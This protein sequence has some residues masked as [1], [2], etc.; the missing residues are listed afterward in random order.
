MVNEPYAHGTIS[1]YKAKK[2]RCDECRA[3]Q[4]EY[5][6]AWRKA[7]G[8]KVGPFNLVC[9]TCASTFVARTSVVKYCSKACLPKPE[10][11]PRRSTCR[12]CR[13]LYPVAEDA[14]R[15]RTGLCARCQ[16]LVAKNQE[17]CGLCGVRWWS[18][19]GQ[20]F[21]S[22]EC[23]NLNDARQAIIEEDYL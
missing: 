7:H 21:C 6:D 15:I 20:A 3:A 10:S 23:R 9:S 12:R 18:G 17:T 4:K 13:I 1:R 8:Q 5:M 2:C 19:D 11:Q 16:A 14:G 22:D